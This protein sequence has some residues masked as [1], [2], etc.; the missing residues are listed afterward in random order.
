MN[1]SLALAI[2]LRYTR[3]S[4]GSALTS[5]ISRISM[6][7]LILGVSVLVAVLAVMNGFER[8][9]EQ[10]ILGIV[11]HFSVYEPGGLSDVRPLQRHLSEL[12][13]VE[14]SYPYVSR[15]GML[16]N[17]AQAEPALFVGVPPD[18][19]HKLGLDQYLAAGSVAGDQQEL[20]IGKLLAE[21]LKVELGSTVT[22]LL[23]Q[24]GLS[25]RILRLTVTAIV[26]T[27]TE[28][29]RSLAMLPIDRLRALSGMAAN[30]AQG[31]HL[32]VDKPLNIVAIGQAVMQTLPYGIYA[33]DWRS[34][35]GN[36][37]QAVQMSKNIVT[38]LVFLIVAIAVFNVIASLMMV[39]NDRRSD[40][41]ILKTLGGGRLFLIQV[42]FCQGA[43]IG[44]L[45]TMLGL[46]LGCL[47][48][49]LLPG[50]AELLASVFKLEFLQAD[51]YPISY[52]PSVLKW[53]DV[54][55][56]GGMAFGMSLLATVFPALTASKTRPAEILRYE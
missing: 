55:L 21:Q 12:E 11:P 2:A 45:G 20:L 49:L 48:A 10:R 34:N 25:P 33:R 43:I 4:S 31:I 24:Q 44:G 23:P 3:L 19:A 38:L 51:V 14:F 15:K 26:N 54:A 36:L 17:A 32:Q 56:V 52:L 39:V 47:F 7:G 27:A 18:T 1:N 46:L 22:L 13:H 16:I 41:A 50:F 35:H 40:I 29:D 9:L 5:F 42:F 28:L 8:E 37:Y 30:S 53:Q 6:L